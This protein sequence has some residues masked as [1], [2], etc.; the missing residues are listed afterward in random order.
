MFKQPHK[1]V[2]AEVHNIGILKYQVQ[3]QSRDAADPNGGH[4]GEQALH[5]SIKMVRHAHG[6]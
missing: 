6:V 5:G 3:E 4:G 2:G 1:T